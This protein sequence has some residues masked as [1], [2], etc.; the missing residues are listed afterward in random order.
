MDLR[1]SIP[2]FI[3][4][5]D[6][7]VCD[8]KIIDKI[9][10]EPGAFYIMDKAYVDFKR[11]SFIEENKGFFVL[12]FKIN[13]NFKRLYSKPYDKQTGVLSDQIGYLNGSVG[14]RKYVNKVRKDIFHDQERN[15][16]LVFMTN[17]FSLPA[18]SIALL[19]KKR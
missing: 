17:N 4:I 10:I 3:D 8:N 1:G 5:S 19:Y 7:S 2:S 12:R 6:A 11:L 14:K 18:D 9:Q 13:I 16:T 15:K